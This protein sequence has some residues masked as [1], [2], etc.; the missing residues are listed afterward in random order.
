MYAVRGCVNGELASFAVNFRNDGLESV[1]HHELFGS[2]RA[3]RRWHRAVAHAVDSRAAIRRRSEGEADA[4]LEL[5]HHQFGCLRTSTDWSTDAAGTRVSDDRSRVRRIL[6]IGVPILGG[7]GSSALLSLVDTA[8]VGWLG[9]AELAAVGLGSFASWI[10]LGFF[11]GLTIAVQALVSRRVGQGRIDEVGRQ[12]QRRAAVAGRSCADECSHSVGGN[13]QPVCVAQRRSGRARRRR[14]VSA[15]G[16]RAVAL[17]RRH[18]CVQRILERHRPIADVHRAAGRHARDEC[19]ARVRVDLRSPRVA[20]DGHGG[21]RARHSARLGGRLRAV[22]RAG[23]SP[24]A[25]AR[26]HACA[27]DARRIRRGAAS[28]GAGRTATALRYAGADPDVSH[29][30]VHRHDR[31]GGVCGADQPGRPRWLAGFCSRQRGGR[32]GRSGARS[33]QC[34]R[35]VAVGVGCAARWCDR[36]GA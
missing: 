23:A 25:T 11:Q 21:R 7:M 6:A 30:R 27:T 24:R 8:M 1:G 3:R 19:G 16:H 20:G 28:R 9:N 26:V 2:L 33:R 32:A 10:Y 12:S 5:V 22:L 13:A 14:A 34:R 31:T 36:V 4:G 29:R 17:H 35:C 18:L 15:L